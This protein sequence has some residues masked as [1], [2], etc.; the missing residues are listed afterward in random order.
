MLR[1]GNK[2]RDT[3][4]TGTVT[5]LAVIQKPVEALRTVPV[6]LGAGSGAR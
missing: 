3:G 2:N 5:F 4:R 1:R 6:I